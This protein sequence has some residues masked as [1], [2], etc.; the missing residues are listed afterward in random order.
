M[1]GKSIPVDSETMVKV[2]SKNEDSQVYQYVRHTHYPLAGNGWILFVLGEPDYDEM[3]DAIQQSA[4]SDT[5]KQRVL[6]AELS[7]I[8]VG[9]EAASRTGAAR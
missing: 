1:H 7:Y 6:S 8:R 2:F 5:G 9:G 4:M 3:I